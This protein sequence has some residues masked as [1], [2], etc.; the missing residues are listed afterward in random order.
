[1]AVGELIETIYTCALD[2]P[3]LLIIPTWATYRSSMSGTVQIPEEVVATGVLVT[4]G[5]I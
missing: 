1:M 4:A 5:I 3:V 2:C